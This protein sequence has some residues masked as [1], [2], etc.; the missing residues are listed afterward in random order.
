MSSTEP[1][2]GQA[3]MP[4]GPLNGITVLDLT[5]VLAGPYCTMVLADLG[6]RVI[7]VEQPGTG[8]DSRAFGPFMKGQ[9]AYFGSLNRGKESIA[10]NLKDDG[11][12]A[13]FG[14]LLTLSDVLVENYRPGTMEKLGLGWDRLHADYPRLIYAAASG[15]GHTGPYSKRAA[16][17]MV[18]QAMGGIMSVTGHPGQ[19][20]VRVGT[21]IGDITAG[22][23]TAVGVNAALYHRALTGE[24]IKVDVGMLDCQVAILENAIARYAATGEVAGPLR[25]APSGDYAFCRL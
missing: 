10:L 6:A 7:K 2:D 16:Y 19:P 14:K 22:L 11:D 24:A 4:H 5:R 20:P 12:K 18:V 15:F 3:Q 25:R 9:S 23:F 1:H 8:D 21:S 13:I 17:D